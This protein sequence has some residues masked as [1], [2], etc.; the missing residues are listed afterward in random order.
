MEL[1]TSFSPQKCFDQK[2]QKTFIYPKQN[3]TNKK[4]HTEGSD[5]NYLYIY[6][7]ILSIEELVI[8]TM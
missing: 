6:N 8:T 4:K 3:E 2:P 7:I 5:M 1:K